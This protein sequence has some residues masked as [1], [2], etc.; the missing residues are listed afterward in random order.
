MKRDPTQR[1]RLLDRVSSIRDVG[2]FLIGSS[3]TKVGIERRSRTL[4]SGMLRQSAEPDRLWVILY[5]F[6]SLT[7]DRIEIR[8]DEVLASVVAIEDVFR[9]VSEHDAWVMQYATLVEEVITVPGVA[10]PLH[11]VPDRLEPCLC[12]RLMELRGVDPI[13]IEER[14]QGA[15]KR[16]DGE[17]WPVGG[18]VN[19][20]EPKVGPVVEERGGDLARIELAT[21]FEVGV[22]EMIHRR[23][24]VRAS[25]VLKLRCR[26]RA[27]IEV[28]KFANGSRSVQSRL[29]DR[30]LRRAAFLEL[31]RVAGDRLRD[32]ALR[33]FAEVLL[34]NRIGLLEL[35]PQR[36]VEERPGYL[37]HDRRPALSAIAVWRQPV[38]PGQRREER[39]RPVV[40]QREAEFDRGLAAL[41]L[42]ESLENSVARAF[43]C[44]A[45]SRR[46][47]A[48]E[49]RLELAELFDE[50]IF[51]IHGAACRCGLETGNP[52]RESI[53]ENR[54]KLDV[55]RSIPIDS[56][57]TPEASSSGGSRRT[58][59]CSKHPC[60]DGD[61]PI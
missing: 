22:G 51:F 50:L 40:L 60:D 12:E 5:L 2:E 14:P 56:Q 27:A 57:H 29:D 28:R 43:G 17:V 33:H 21:E 59:I 49:E 19:I 11:E 54:H 48:V 58:R 15:T 46:S 30:F 44:G 8:F 41:E 1:R 16:S 34:E 6:S 47:W 38:A 9:I 45:L 31:R 10:E 35:G 42:T 20:G 61:T 39:V 23:H 18:Q 4:A 52:G 25:R 36:F 3:I 24:S 32:D 37:Q 13:A 26:V 7:R 53:V 55:P